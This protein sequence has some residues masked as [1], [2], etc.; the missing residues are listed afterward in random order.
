M[1]T[2]GDLDRCTC[3]EIHL[4]IAQDV[5]YICIKLQPCGSHQSKNI[6]TQGFAQSPP[7][8]SKSS[9]YTSTALALKSTTIHIYA[10]KLSS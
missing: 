5:L 10:I 9:S 6:C 2:L 1:H 3:A 7:F 4:F 8:V